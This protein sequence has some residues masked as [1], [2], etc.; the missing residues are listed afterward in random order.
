MNVGYI[1]DMTT[2]AFIGLIASTSDGIAY[3]TNDNTLN[4]ILD[5]ILNKD[6][7]PLVSSTEHRF[8]NRDIGVY[9]NEY[10]H[11]LSYYLP[12]KFNIGKLKYIDK[13]LSELNDVYMEEINLDKES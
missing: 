8:I 13:D 6:K 9:D 11:A 2:D 5:I 3:I 12:D 1:Y 4:S 10:I 7:L